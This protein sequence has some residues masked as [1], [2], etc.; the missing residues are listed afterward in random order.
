MLSRNNILFL[1]ENEIRKRFLSPSLCCE[2]ISPEFLDPSLRES[3]CPIAGFLIEI[4]DDF[5]LEK[6][7][8]LPKIM[9]REALL[10]S[11]K[12]SYFPIDIVLELLCIG[13]EIF[14]RRSIFWVYLFE[15]W[16]NIFS[17]MIAKVICIRIT[18]VLTV[19]YMVIMSIFED[20]FFRE[21]EEWTKECSPER[22]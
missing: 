10:F 19:C 15:F 1:R 6:W 13:D 11:E 12:C 18:R 20:F 8:F 2:D 14:E 17:K 7:G 5:S 3:D 9:H 4:S 21:R 22:K 16:K